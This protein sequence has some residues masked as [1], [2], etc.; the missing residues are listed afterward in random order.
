M[1]DKEQLLHLPTPQDT[2]SPNPKGQGMVVTITLLYTAW[3][4][5]VSH[6]FQG[7]L[8]KTGED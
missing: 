7:D 6:A 8:Q 3:L 2:Y 1:T 5:Y 4:S